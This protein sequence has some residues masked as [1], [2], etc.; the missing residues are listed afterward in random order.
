MIKCMTLTFFLFFGLT[1]AADVEVSVTPNKPVVITSDYSAGGHFIKGP[2]F[3]FD[4]ALYNQ[5]AQIV[6]VIGARV[7]V[8]GRDY[9][10][11]K[12]SVTAAFSPSDFNTVLTCSNGTK[13][14]VAFSD[15]GTYSPGSTAYLEL[16]DQTPL[17]PDCTG[18][19]PNIAPVTFY[20][21]GLPP[22]GMSSDFDYDVDLELIGWTGSSVAPTARF[23]QHFTFGTQ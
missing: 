23:N 17:P 14:S 11:V 12:T 13:V 19:S 1:A 2:W 8:S 10:G 22:H 3:S 5:T 21:A 16:L 7:T 6:T 18:V 9:E 20:A 15:F 4:V